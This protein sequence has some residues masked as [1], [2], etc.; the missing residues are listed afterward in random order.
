MQTVHLKICFVLVFI[1][2]Q[3]YVLGIMGF[4]AV[5]NAYTMRTSLSVAITEMVLPSNSTEVDPNACPA[6]TSNSS[7]NTVTV[8][9]CVV[10]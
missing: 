9:N 7:S 5:L 10:N 4:F 3:R 6:D 2:P 1:I 8:R